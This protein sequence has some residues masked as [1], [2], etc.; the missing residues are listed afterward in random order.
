MAYDRYTGRSI[1][2][3]PVFWM[4][5]ANVTVQTGGEGSRE[6]RSRAGP[7]R[8]FLGNQSSFMEQGAGAPAIFSH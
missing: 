2:V 4:V 6:V 7:V 3:L 8:W 1:I 5:I